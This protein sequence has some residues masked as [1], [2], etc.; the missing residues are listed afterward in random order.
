MRL[1][2]FDLKLPD[3]RV[4]PASATAESWQWSAA[5]SAACR[6]VERRYGLLPYAGTTCVSYSSAAFDAHQPELLHAA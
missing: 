1:F 4:V 6:E 5:F 2:Q 3:G